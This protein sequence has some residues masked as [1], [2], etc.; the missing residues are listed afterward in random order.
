M[1]KRGKVRIYKVTPD[2]WE[3][4]L[5]VVESGTMPAWRQPVRDGGGVG[6]RRGD[7]PRMSGVL[8]EDPAP[9]SAKVLRYHAGQRPPSL[10]ESTPVSSRQSVYE[11][12]ISQ[13][14]GHEPKPWI[15]H[16]Q[17][18]RPSG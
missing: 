2:G 6:L 8:P 18:G 5:A 12:S 11:N 9:A 17:S 1:L 13:G 14:V 3:F 16:P 10:Q 4:T 7:G 15:D